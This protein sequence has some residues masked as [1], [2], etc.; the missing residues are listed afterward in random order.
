MLDE[1]VSRVVTVQTANEAGEAQVE[2]A[3][4]NAGDKFVIGK[5]YF[6]HQ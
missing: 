2:V 6:S 3:A 4:I 5:F 1:C